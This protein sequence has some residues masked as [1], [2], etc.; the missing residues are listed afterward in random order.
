M[1]PE[2][3][4]PADALGP[5]ARAP[6]RIG[7]L[8]VPQ[9]SMIAFASAVEPLRLANRVL[10]R[11]LYEFGTYSLDGRPV[12]A[13]NGL[14]IGVDARI[15]A[16]ERL[17]TVFVCGGLDVR[18][19]AERPLLAELRRLA[20]RGANLGAMCTGSHVL[21]KAG[22]L[23]GHRCTIHWENLSAFHEDFPDIDVTSELFEIDRNRYTCAGGTAAAD[24][25]LN[26]IALEAG[27]AVAAQVADQL[28]HHPIREGREG[29]R[30][31][32]R[33][34][35]GVAHPK[36]LAVIQRMEESLETPVRCR[37]LAAAVGLSGRQLERLFRNYLGR[38]P[39]RH[40]LDLRLERARFLLLQT[41][42]P[43][44]GVA[45]ACGFV[46]AAHFAKCFRDSFGTTPSAARRGA[47]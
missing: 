46:S 22:L 42:L 45:L 38:S 27:H 10:G 4:S 19:H 25:M 15:G 37:E 7:F 28:I 47:A 41:S 6:H 43:V 20:A 35:L 34:R 31:E 11:E 29:Q 14:S 36:L 1:S 3:A 21:A 32:L 9:F 44:M 30:M 33:S 39:T 40:Y 23:D 16:A 24:L 18:R 17:A 2:R 5:R 8:L 12:R 13:S 26:L